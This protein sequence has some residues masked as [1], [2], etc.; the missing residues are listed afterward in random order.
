LCQF[1]T[2]LFYIFLT[3]KNICKCFRVYICGSSYNSY[4]ERR[5]ENGPDEALTTLAITQS[6][7]GAKSNL[8]VTGVERR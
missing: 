3:S 2:K 6:Q 4:Q 7:E 5:R 1:N 8:N